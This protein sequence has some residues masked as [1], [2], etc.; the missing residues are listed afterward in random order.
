MIEKVI[1][2]L[3]VVKEQFGDRLI[4]TTGF[5]YSGIV[6]LHHIKEVI[7]DLP[8]YFID[9]GYHFKE[10]LDLRDYIMTTWNL[11]I[12]TISNLEAEIDYRN[13]VDCCYQR[14]V[15]PLK[16]IM[17]P[18]SVW[19]SALRKDQSAHRGTTTLINKDSRG[20]TKICPLWD[21]NKAQLWEYIKDNRLHY[22]PLHDIGYPSIGC[23]PCTSPVEEGEDERSG[24]WKDTCKAG[25]E[26]GMHE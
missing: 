5:G 19:I 20:N 6:L 23:Q 25:G 12:I 17:K 9:T 21:L 16:Q 15:V 26:C 14:K 18:D 22:N 24:R 11:N 10:T 13:P 7:P 3:A 8:I 1:D 4:M 2:R